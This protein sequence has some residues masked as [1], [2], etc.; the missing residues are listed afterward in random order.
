MGL[1][2]KLSSLGKMELSRQAG[3]H[4]EWTKDI[5]NRE[6]F[7]KVWTLDVLHLHDPAPN[8]R[9]RIPGVTPAWECISL[10]NSLVF[11]YF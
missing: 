1:R 11:Y 8:H 3:G 6:I 4:L 5:G 10:T 2:G 7:L 9:I